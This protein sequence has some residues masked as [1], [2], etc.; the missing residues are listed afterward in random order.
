VASS[1]GDRPP[2]LLVPALL[3]L[4]LLLLLPPAMPSAAS[5][6]RSPLPL[7]A[8][9]LLEGVGRTKPPSARHWKHC[10]THGGVA[11]CAGVC[12]CVPVRH[13][14]NGHAHALL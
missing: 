2:L 1:L 12:R 3:L 10:H 14:Q 6:L 4:L 13:P 11:A 9:L 7:V 5:A 8:A